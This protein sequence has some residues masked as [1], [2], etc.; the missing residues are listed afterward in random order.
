MVNLRADNRVDSLGWTESHQKLKPVNPAFER[1]RPQRHKFK[2][3]LGCRQNHQKSK[4][5]NK[6]IPVLSQVLRRSLCAF[7]E[8]YSGWDTAAHS[9]VSNVTPPGSLPKL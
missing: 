3:C 9:R 6:R 1:I 2:A 8:T 5:T 4:Q 7:R